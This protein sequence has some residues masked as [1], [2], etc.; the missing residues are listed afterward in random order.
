MRG[1]GPEVVESFAYPLVRALADHREIFSNLCGFSG[2][3]FR[4][5]Q[6]DSLES[7]SGAW[8]TGAYYA[9][10]GLQP[11]AGRFLAEA[12]DQP[13]AVPVAV[14]TD[15]YWE[16]KFGRNPR[17]IGQQILVEGKPVT[18]AGVSPRGFTG[19]NAGE[20]ADITLPLGVLTQLSTNREL[21]L[22]PG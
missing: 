5:G 2:A 7:T 8:V 15:G 20:I 9:T 21:Q 22:D 4:V 14:V 18:I 10:L 19:A 17:A 11:V 1:P 3:R 16:R 13:G 12:D 6:G